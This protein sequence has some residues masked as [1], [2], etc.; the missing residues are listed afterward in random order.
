MTGY[1]LHRDLIPVKRIPEKALWAAV[2]VQA[3]KDLEGR[4]FGNTR[5]IE[6]CRAN[7]IGWIESNRADYLGSFLCVCDLLDLD[8]KVVRKR[9]N[10]G[11]KLEHQ[12]PKQ[13]L[14]VT[15]QIL[16]KPT[17]FENLTCSEIAVMFDTNKLNIHKI[18]SKFGLKYKLLRK[19]RNRL[20]NE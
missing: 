8:P 4:T 11:R 6:I 12:A 10:E 20:T 13:K 19:R 1:R 9:F 14:S 3:F 17:E 15:K 18:M 5:M 7:A 2:L 16:D